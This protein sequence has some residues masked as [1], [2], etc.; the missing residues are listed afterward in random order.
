MNFNNIEDLDDN[1]IKNFYK[2]I[3][4]NVSRIRK[5]H[6][7]SQLELSLLL[8]H[9]SSSQVSGSEICYKN[10]HFNIEQLAKIAYILNE[11]ISEFIK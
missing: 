7:L 6:K 10:Y 8:G 1:Y 4:K 5:K 11:D 2:S 3:G 9:K